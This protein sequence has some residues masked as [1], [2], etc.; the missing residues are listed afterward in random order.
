MRLDHQGRIPMAQ[1]GVPVIVCRVPQ[2]LQTRGIS[3]RT[4]ARRT[5]LSR[6]TIAK[7]CADEWVGV[8]RWTLAAICAAL[9]VPVGRLLTVEW[10]ELGPTEIGAERPT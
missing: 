1:K 10:R 2:L 9:D 4:L 7:L 8:D 3:Q 6:T 5:H